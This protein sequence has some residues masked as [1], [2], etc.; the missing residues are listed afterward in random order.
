MFADFIIKNAAPII[1]DRI[2]NIIKNVAS[3]HH[4]NAY[5]VSAMLKL[6]YQNETPLNGQL[7]VFCFY[8]NKKVERFPLNQIQDTF[9]GTA[10]GVIKKIFMRDALLYRVEPAYVNYVFKILTG[11]ALAVWPNIAGEYKEQLT[12]KQI[13]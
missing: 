6:V 10:E 8:Q 2:K 5:D 9:M 12:L 3:K 4:L 11:D 7:E 1:E 13:L